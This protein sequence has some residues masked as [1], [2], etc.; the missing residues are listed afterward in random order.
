MTTKKLASI[1]IVLKLV[2][3]RPEVSL[4]LLKEMRGGFEVL[5]AQV[6]L[7]EARTN[8]IQALRDYSV[9]RVG[10]EQA[11]GTVRRQTN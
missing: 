9:A 2:W 10:I 1:L 7:T 5:D 11:M 3:S 6:Q 4:H 8:E